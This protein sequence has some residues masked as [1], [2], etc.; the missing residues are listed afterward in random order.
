[1]AVRDRRPSSLILADEE[2]MILY[3]AIPNR[4]N[5]KSV[6]AKYEGYVLTD[7]SGIASNG[8][9]RRTRKPMSPSIA[10]PFDILTSMT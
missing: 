4:I 10:T 7:I 5:S 1:M 9:M 6:A 2:K 3:T 8:R